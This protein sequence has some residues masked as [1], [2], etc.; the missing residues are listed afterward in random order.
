MAVKF[1]LP[2]GSTTDLLCQAWPAFPS[3]TPAE[4]LE[5]MQA[6]IAGPGAHA[7]SSSSAVP[8]TSV[9]HRGATVPRSPVMAALVPRREQS[10]WVSGT[11]MYVS[12][13]MTALLSDRD[14][15]C[16]RAS[17]RTGPTAP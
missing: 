9:Q 13:P 3:R 6:Q 2:D 16:E 14:A 1:Y 17:V 8:Q 5:L 11:N 10:G 4:F 15:G 7:R 12:D